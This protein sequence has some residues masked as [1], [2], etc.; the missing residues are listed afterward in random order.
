MQHR[1]SRWPTGTGGRWGAAARLV[2]AAA[3]LAAAVL[4]LG[5]SA[6]AGSA[7]TTVPSPTAGG[8]SMLGTA[9]VVTTTSPSTLQ[10]TDAATAG[11][12]AGLAYWPTAV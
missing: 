3:V 1:A 10:L 11:H 5:P 4:V 9:K 2:P 6:P 7:T 8:W 12:E